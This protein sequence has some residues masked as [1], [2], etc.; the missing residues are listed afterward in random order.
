MTTNHSTHESATFAQDRVYEIIDKALDFEDLL[1]AADS[2]LFAVQVSGADAAVKERQPALWEAAWRLIGD[3]SKRHDPTDRE[4]RAQGFFLALQAI[5]QTPGTLD[6]TLEHLQD[7]LTVRLIPK[8]A[9]ILREGAA[10]AP[11]TKWYDNTAQMPAFRI[12][13]RALGLEDDDA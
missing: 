7:A 1:K 12:L 10:P 11:S 3:Q 9:G 2:L 4:G 6:R 13:D 8:D 5:A